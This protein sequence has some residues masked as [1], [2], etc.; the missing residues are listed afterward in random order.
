MRPGSS[1]H[2]LVAACATWALLGGALAGFACLSN[3]CVYGICIDDL[4]STYTC[5][6]IDGYT[7]VHCQTNWDEC[8]SSPCLNGGTCTDGVAAFNCTCPDGYAGAFCETD[9]AVCNATGESRC[10]NGGLCIEGPGDTFTCSCLAGWTGEL[11]NTSIDEC[12]S[13]PCLNG[14]VCVDR[15]ADYACA[16]PFGF[17]GK[18]CEVQLH[19]CTTSPC[20]NNALCL[21]ED[22]VRVCYCVPDYHGDRCQFQY[23]ECQLGP[24]CLNGGTC[25]DGVDN[26]TCTCPPNL[27]GQF[28]ECLIIDPEH[29]NCTYIVPTTMTTTIT[30]LLPPIISE[31]PSSVT[32]KVPS[33]LSTTSVSEITTKETEITYHVPSSQTLSWTSEYTT[34]SIT[35]TSEITSS[36]PTFTTALTETTTS[37]EML[38]I[39]TITGTVTSTTDVIESTTLSTDV[40]TP[41]KPSDSTEGLLTTA[42]TNKSEVSTATEESSTGTS[43]A[44]N[45]IPTETA[46]VVSEQ[47]TFTPAVITTGE[48]TPTTESPVTVSVPVTDEDRMYSSSSEYP[49]YST[50][51]STLDTTA[52][53]ES[54]S[55]STAL[56]DCSITPCLNGGTC[57][58]TKEGPQ[59]VCKFGWE[60]ALC[61]ERV[62]IRVAAFTGQ[63]Y[64]SHR[65]GNS[66]GTH[67]E[68]AAR[69]MAPTGVLLYAHLTP[70]MYMY[71][72][73]ED[74]LL[75][76]QFSCGVQTMLFSEVQLRVNNGFDLAVQVT[77]ELLPS[78]SEFRRCAASLRIN[79]TLAMSGEQMAVTPTPTRADSWL[80][81]AGIPPQFLVPNEAPLTVGF[82][83]CMQ[84]LKIDNRSLS[85]FRDAVDG[86]D[87]TECS[88][89][90]C[91][92]NPCF[93]SAT[94]I[95][96]KDKWH[97]L[98]PSGF[99]GVTCEQSVCEVN[100]CQ[101]GSTC[102]PYPASGFLCLCPLGKHGI[103]CEHDLEI[104]QPS[105]S[106]SVGG[107]A[108]YAAYPIPGAIHN[109]MEL[110]FKFVPTTTEQIALMVFIGQDG[111]H[112]SRADHLSV[113]FIKGYVVLTWNLGS[114]PRRIFTPRP[115]TQR[116]NRP[117]TV[118][119]G[120]TG[121]LA[122]LLVDNLGNVS[123][124]SPGRLSQLNTR[125]LLYLGGHES[126]NFSLLPHDLP[127]HTGFSGCL[128]DVELR[129][130]RVS[131]A[132][133][134]IQAATGRSVGQCGTSECHE[135]ACQHG[136]AC[137]HHGA[138]YTCLCPEGWFGPVCSLRFN[139]CDSTRHNCSSGSTCVPL[140]TGYECDCPLGKAGRHC[141]RDEVLSDV[142]FS[143]TRSFLS[144][145]PVELHHQQA[146]IHFEVRP[147]HDRGL[148]LFV[149]HR[150]G[151]SF[152]SLSLQGGVLE[153]RVSPG[154]L[155]KNGEPIVVRSGHV[156]AIGEWHQVVAGHYGRRIFLQVDGL[157]HSAAMLPGD[158]LP[159]SGTPLYLGGVP[160]LSELPI[161]AVSGLPTPFRGC[162]RQVSLN[163][164][165]I[166]L[167]RD[168]ILTARNVADCDGTGCGGDV[169]DHGGS[170]WLDTH[171]VAHCT[172]RQEYTGSRCE[173]QVS[174][175]EYK[176]HNNGRC[177]KESS[178]ARCH[179][180]LGWGGDFC[181]EAV[182]LG[183][184]HFGGNS[185]LV[186]EKAARVMRHG[187]G[188][189]KTGLD[190]NFV[191]LNFS[192]AD[193]N[194]MILWSAKGNEFIGIGVDYGLLKLVWGWS[195]PVGNKIL[196]PAGSVA[197]GDWHSLSLHLGPDNIT[198]WVDNTLVHSKSRPPQVLTTDG[199]FYLGG[200]PEDK[201]VV[202]GTAGHFTSTFNGCI[203]EFAWAED[204]VITDFSRYKGE[205]IGSCDLLQP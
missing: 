62:G 45:G 114:G 151:R 74:G 21:V 197:D 13:S 174:C 44:T 55:S 149:G 35:S 196:I 90:A 10:M 189:L 64:L 150:D 116:G 153:L 201:S 24:R 140:P 107:L 87:V 23:D 132:L 182:T 18:N 109:S 82:T 146:T 70:D 41:T 188:S 133:Q 106:S 12:A 202:E 112:D 98:C 80:H 129:A 67:I 33:T 110:K 47:S 203:T 161:G 9:E 92:S 58:H 183:A 135:H 111:F 6:C 69:T 154:R 138:T 123:G 53:M 75:K 11:C 17:T 85:V 83:G 195:S 103:Y 3:P 34:H 124:K 79:S 95:E 48:T 20:E 78:S 52:Y 158:M 176:C 191:Y 28:C 120:R 40:R 16:C 194:G 61:Q 139:P 65:L 152:L 144:L 184:P 163:W 164:K 73:L 19:Q 175:L 97:C 99:V 159:S 115:V 134:R 173:T 102:V 117:H 145:P 113:S 185:Y 76:F 30:T 26:F 46:S 157:L 127:L 15:H 31:F 57:I 190:I 131:V 96:H 38:S 7:G 8:W 1:R 36:A 167:D 54:S 199:T 72:Y 71:L 2:V 25:L 60:G 88:S 186:I 147:F 141:E 128:F 142:A 172:C 101:F 143:G 68:V 160:D 192:T 22:G 205:N 94:C 119:L 177:V 37:S 181:D 130:G 14:G 108:S 66:M 39:P 187:G 170:C 63:S 136:G 126:G 42:Y 32:A 91:L 168:H 125:S 193:L 155:R 180:P 59:C 86:Y 81:L 93:G 27:T 84:A 179:C 29:L 89:L 43:I 50:T 156:L 77:L 204:A 169:C 122:W 200:F 105:F 165:R 100:P 121:Q 171:H 56:P 148:L 118:R 198:L 162:I 166:V 4:N 5:Y 137:L 49:T 178:T 104:G 51:L